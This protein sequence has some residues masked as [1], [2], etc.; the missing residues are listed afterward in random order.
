MRNNFLI[1]SQGRTGTLFLSRLMNSSKK[2]KVKHQPDKRDATF[3]DVGGTCSYFN[4][5]FPDVPKHIINRFDQDYYGEV[6][7]LLR[8]YFSGLEVNKKGI[9]YRNPKDVIVSFANGKGNRTGGQRLVNK[10]LDINL[11]HNYFYDLMKKNNSI[12]LINFENMFS[13]LKYLK[14]V[15]LTF[16]IDDVRVNNFIMTKKVNPSPKKRS[17]EKLGVESFVDALDWKDYNKLNNWL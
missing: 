12:I 1:T 7:G 4:L 5:D 15:L 10:I 3:E 13:D 14:K 16:G 9:I 17:Y 2:W 11:V 8:Y 6:N